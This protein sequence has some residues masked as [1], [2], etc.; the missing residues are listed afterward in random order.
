[1]LPKLF[2]KY[3][4]AKSLVGARSMQALRGT[5]RGILGAARLPGRV[6]GGVLSA[7][8]GATGFS[9]ALS[10]AS[11]LFPG[12]RRGGRD[13][14]KSETGLLNTSI[15][16]QIRDE[17][18]QIKGLLVATAVPESERREREFDEQRRHRELLAA[19][20][21]LGGGGGRGMAAAK[22]GGL[23]ALLM[24]LLAITGLAM[25]PKLLENLPS[26]IDG[27]QNAMDSIGL[28]LLGMWGAFKLL[29]RK[30]N[31]IKPPKTKTV[32]S[33]DDKKKAAKKRAADERRAK[34]AAA[35]AAK[36]AETARFK[37][38]REAAKKIKISE[39]AARIKAAQEAKLKRQQMSKFAGQRKGVMDVKAAQGAER[40]QRAAALKAENVKIKQ[41]AQG[42][43]ELARFQSQ[44]RAVAENKAFEKRAQAQARENFK[45]GLT[46]DKA[47]QERSAKGDR[48][49]RFRLQMNNTYTKMGGLLKAQNASF[50]DAMKLSDNAF[51]KFSNR[52]G[53]R[54][55]EF[56]R[57]INKTTAGIQQSVD[58]IKKTANSVKAKVAPAKSFLRGGGIPQETL[59]STPDPRVTA[60][61]KSQAMAGEGSKGGFRGKVATVAAK[62]FPT[63]RGS[64]GAGM[65][66]GEGSV[67]ATS[68]TNIPSNVLKAFTGGNIGGPG[69]GSGV[70]SVWTSPI[71]IPQLPGVL[72]RF[73]NSLKGHLI[74][75][76][77]GAQKLGNVK[78]VKALGKIGLIVMIFAS[79][80]GL[81]AARIENKITWEDFMW[82]AGIELAK[83]AGI[84]VLFIAVMA[85]VGTALAAAAPVLAASLLGGIAT[86]VI[87]TIITE[88]IMSMFKDPKKPKADVDPYEVWLARSEKM[89]DAGHGMLRDPDGTVLTKVAGIT[90]LASAAALEGVTKSARAIA[91]LFS[92]TKKTAP[93]GI[94]QY[95]G[96]GRSKRIN[97]AWEKAHRVNDFGQDDTLG[98]E[99]EGG[100]GSTKFRN[101]NSPAALQSAFAKDAAKAAKLSPPP[102]VIPDN[103]LMSKG[104]RRTAIKDL[105]KKIREHSWVLER[106]KTQEARLLPEL[107]QLNQEMLNL[108]NAPTDDASGHII[109]NHQEIKDASV[110]TTSVQQSSTSATNLGYSMPTLG[111]ATSGRF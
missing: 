10:M 57:S 24:G 12:G 99:D 96:K 3:G 39:K 79:L 58:D 97:P 11:G 105:K 36:A 62:I 53:S 103:I 16:F 25:L 4:S 23:A 51:K 21:T 18:A 7:V 102:K 101:Q 34:K 74:K 6:A 78:A 19:I 35:R 41:A 94:P 30:F 33:A 83:L 67:R 107:L 56:R 1:M 13:G 54:M 68:K 26:L 2:G 37:A 55:D 81:V 8:A 17:V 106:D 42:R 95:L 28:F 77:E 27:I 108:I 92:T 64:I 85:V 88:V 72:G 52:M 48:A 47:A 104:D 110:T 46:P 65:G 29:G 9:G 66:G 90:I 86:V 43:K 14:S 50:V 70:K 80:A 109:V 63:T 5:G 32:L 75:G 49:T 45:K 20:S 98:E 93:E 38:Q 71:K 15:L 40:A 76:L 84:I 44:Q 22:G 61:N 100:M 82:Q 111:H 73:A 59:K 31:L 89:V 69:G 91:G 60:A 87:G